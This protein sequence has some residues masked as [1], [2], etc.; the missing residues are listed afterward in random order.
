MIVVTGSLAF[1]HIM[2]FPGRF[3][4]HILPDKIHVINLSFEVDTFER[5][6]GGTAGNIV[7]GAALLDEQCIL[8]AASGND[9]TQYRDKLLSMSINCDHVIVADDLPTARLYIMTDQADNQIAAFYAGAMSRASELS[10][11]SLGRPGAIDYVHIAPDNADAMINHTSWC[12]EHEVPYIFDPG[13]Q[14]I[15]LDADAIRSGV[16]LAHGI[17]GNDY[18]ISMIQEKTGLDLETMVDLTEAVIVTQGA[19]GSQLYTSGERYD[20][21]V[22]APE[23]VVDP[24]GAG[25]SYRAGLLVGLQRG[26]GWR[27]SAQL[28]STL[29]SFAVQEYG[30]QEYRCGWDD[31]IDRYNR[32]YKTYR[33]DQ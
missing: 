14:L 18:E 21:D 20:I 16:T 7:Y 26:W 2:N 19:Q 8:L 3:S 29:A 12:Q 31:V 32:T 23:L 4:D 28:G 6:F 17:I 24:T 13:Q 25:D 9:F 22:V 30:T 10:I 15:K 5:R 11:G 33:T 27:K 1:D